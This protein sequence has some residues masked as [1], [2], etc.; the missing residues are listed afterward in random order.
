MKYIKN[1]LVLFI[2]FFVSINVLS[3]KDFIDLYSKNAILYNL[4]DNTVLYELNSKDRVKIASLT[5]IMS[6]IVAI[7]NVKDVNSKVTIT[8]KSLEGLAEADASVAGFQVG[9]QVTYLDLLYGALLPSGADAVHALAINIAGSLE[10]YVKLM[11]DKAKTLNLKNTNF[12]S[13]TGL[14]ETNQYSTVEDVAELLKYALKNKIFKEIFTKRA[15]TTTNGLVM[16]STLVYYGS[17]Y[18]QSTRNI[19]GAKTGYTDEAGLCMASISNIDDMNLLLVTTGAS[20]SNQRI[21]QIKDAY[22]VYDYYDKNYK[23]MA[24][25]EEGDL[26]TEIMTKY[27][28]REYID[29]Y[30]SESVEKILPEAATE[31][32]ITLEYAGISL[33]T[34]DNK[35]G[36]KLGIINV[37]YKGDVI[38]TINV[39]LNEEIHFNIFRF[40]KE[41][42][43]F[44]I[45]GLLVIVLSYLR[46]VKIKK[47]KKSYKYKSYYN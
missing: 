19:L 20:A 34:P 39:M 29:F 6:A 28:R 18:N 26:L 7:E 21:Y 36:S 37:M 46:I 42:W 25:V 13:V 3:A 1:V 23:E 35:V 33:L 15:Y 5:K 17:Q 22:N 38:D 45:M 4:N 44:F 16:N 30:A 12:T 32:D 11:N 8:Y 31:D 10:N 14:D 2:V 43:I 40:I 9:Q 27:D 24:V 47:R 41:N